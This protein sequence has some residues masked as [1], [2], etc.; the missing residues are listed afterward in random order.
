MLKLSQLDEFI[1]DVEVISDKLQYTIENPSTSKE[2][3][4][5]YEEMQVYSVYYLTILKKLELM[6]DNPNEKSE[7]EKLLIQS[8]EDISGFIKI[9]NNFLNYK[10]EQ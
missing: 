10:D 1:I 6:H 3:K 4:T 2:K 7:G 8:H 5:M 9:A